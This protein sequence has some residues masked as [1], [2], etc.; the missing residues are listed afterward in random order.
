MNDQ[1]LTDEQLVTMLSESK[2]KAFN[3]IYA[4]YWKMLYAVAYSQLGT[5]EEAEDIVHNVFERIWNNRDIQKINCLK[6]S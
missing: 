1:S 6:A 2:I 3:A 4:R 5:K